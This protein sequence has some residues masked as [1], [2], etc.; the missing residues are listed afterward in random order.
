M[1][2]AN[3]TETTTYSDMLL[4][5]QVGP[6]VNL[7]PTGPWDIVSQTDTGLVMIHHRPDADMKFYG[8]L[9]GVCVDIN[10]GTVVCYSFPHSPQVVT[11][12]LSLTNDKIVLGDVSLDPSKVKIKPG[13]EGPLIHVFKHD[14]Q[15]YRSTRKRF[16]PSKSRWGNSKTF[17][18]MYWQLSGPSDE[19]L[20]DPEKKY[21]PYCHTFIMVHPQMLVCT[22]DNVGEGHLVYLGPK[23]MY[24]TD[25]NCPYPVEEVDTD[26]RVPETVS[27]VTEEKIYSPQILSLEEANK[28]LLFGFYDGFEGY[29]HL[30]PRLLP[31]EF[32]ILEDTLTGNMYRVE[33]PS[34]HWRSTMR[35]NNPNI[36]HRFYELMDYSYLKNSEEDETKYGK[37]FPVLTFFDLESLD[38][39]VKAGPIVVWPQDTEKEFGIPN[40]REAKL[41]NIWQCFLAA[42]PLSR[43]QEVVE[44]YMHMKARNEEIIAW[45]IQLSEQNPD[46]DGFSKRVKDILSKT[47]SFAV[48]RVKKGDNF[49]RKTKKKKGVREI[50]KDNIRNFINK[51]MGSSLYRILKEMDRY[52]NPLPIINIA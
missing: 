36:L 47:K 13:F 7:E 15:V 20:F 16:D 12:A 34:Y 11:S 22:R 42:V 25:E 33:S 45:L 38:A 8:A 14:G 52:K 21:S 32:V 28:H 26:L 46:M 35:N 9:R 49:D 37:A 23:Q 51:E 10:T 24:S 50:T 43:Q 6:M 48:A 1:A 18:E 19:A 30:D 41:Y 5:E 44:Y 31:G 4:K 2:N 17:D 40:T 3:F 29:E 39:S 27:E